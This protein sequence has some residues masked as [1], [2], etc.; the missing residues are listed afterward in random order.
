MLGKACPAHGSHPMAS[1]RPPADP[2]KAGL[3][4]RMLSEGSGTDG[5]GGQSLPEK[6]LGQTLYASGAPP[7]LTSCPRVRVLEALRNF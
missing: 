6:H 4:G 3:W 2:E 5:G 1:L 7:G